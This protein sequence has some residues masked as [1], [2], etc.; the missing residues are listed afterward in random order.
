MS[1]ITIPCHA[2]SNRR[3]SCKSAV[4]L[5]CPPQV[6]ALLAAMLLAPAAGAASNEDDFNDNSKNGSKWGADRVINKGLLTERN[7]RLEYTVSNGTVED[8]AW[9]PWKLT[10]FPY[11]GDWEFR[12]DVF[13]NTLPVAPLQLNS[14]GVLIQT[15]RTNE[16]EMFTELYSSALGGPW[17]RGFD[18]ELETDGEDL[19]PVDSGEIIGLSN[20]ALR[21]TFENATKIITVFY[22]LE[23]GDGYQWV[24]QASFGLAGNGGADD[25]TDWRMTDTDQFAITIYGFSVGMT[26]ASGQ[27]YVDNFSETGG[28]TPSD[29]PTPDPVGTFQF[30]FPTNNTLLTRILSI[31]GNYTGFTTTPHQR[32][33][34]VDVAQDESGKLLAMGT[35][36]GIGSATGDNQIS[37]VVGTVT[38]ISGKPTATLK[39]NFDITRDGTPIK[40]KGTMSG[41]LEV[42]DISVETRGLTGSQKG[43]AKVAGLPLSMKSTGFV[44]PVAPSHESNLQSGWTLHLDIQRKLIGTKERT[45]ASAL[46]VLPN[47]DSV[48][49]AERVARY[50][51]TK[52]Y[53]LSFVRGTNITMNPATIDKKSTIALKGLTFVQDGASWEPAGG[54]ITYRFL[55]QKGTANLM[56]FLAP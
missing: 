45:V 26:I 39:G 54:T 14:I 7:Q 30:A 35:V 44:V 8:D 55:G 13:N 42:T 15:T 34:G 25:N 3:R 17:R 29:A 33:Y 2:S 23:T 18:T 36:A 27:M 37:G 22:D 9:R 38:T 51:A 16:H 47:G 46:L 53:A 31:A 5:H 12:F 4:S 11:N 20:A 40:A 19:V 6:L 49:Y 43:T 24:Q 1:E 28:V 52:G 21:V 32:A 10:R 41:S 48:V 56:D 50:S